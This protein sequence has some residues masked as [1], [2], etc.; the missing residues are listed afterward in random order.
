LRAETAEDTRAVGE[1]VASLLRAGDAVAL[2]GE[3]GAGKTTFVQGAARA[4]GVTRAVVSP[5]FTLVREYRGR[6]PVYHVDVY[7][8]DRVQDVL[9][10]GLEEMSDEGVLFVEW[11]DVVEAL[12]PESYLLIELTT[13]PDGDARRLVVA[14]VGPAWRARWERL[15]RVTERW[16]SAA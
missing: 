9:D 5:T 11:G 12:L 3:L 6:L 13:E 2:T 14:G 16:G 1:A 15:E 8:L 7:R 4:L 10:L